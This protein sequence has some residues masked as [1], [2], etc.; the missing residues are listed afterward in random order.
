MKIE[1]IFNN[2]ILQSLNKNQT[3]QREL[4]DG[5]IKTSKK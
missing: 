4:K 1:K 3:T 5:C 2:I